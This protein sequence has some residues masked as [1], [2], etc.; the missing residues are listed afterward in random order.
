ML[1][2]LLAATV[3]VLA[4]AVIGLF[5]MMG[6]LA[7]RVDKV[8]ADDQSVDA[9]S[10]P[11]E[12]ARIGARVEVWPVQLK[13]LSDV[14]QLALM[15]LSTSCTSCARIAS[16]ETGSLDRAGLPLAVV[17]VGA[18][19]ASVEQFI[20][21]HPL[22]R[23]LPLLEDA[24]GA[25][26]FENFGVDVSPSLLLLQQG[27]LTRAHTFTAASSIR[28]IIENADSAREHHHGAVAR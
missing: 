20:A 26:T 2:A 8:L 6:E 11:L 27:R 28:M 7:G 21:A 25:W 4:V 23:S 17:V 22:L 9:I 1:E 24:G 14:D 5:A 19:E 18:D 3:F 16:G 10:Q 15:V 12:R 13:A